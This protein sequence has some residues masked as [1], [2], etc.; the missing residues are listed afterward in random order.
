MRSG[1]RIDFFVLTS[2]TWKIQYQLCMSMTLY[3]LLTSC[4]DYWSLSFVVGYWWL[5][6]FLCNSI[7]ILS[8]FESFS[9]NARFRFGSLLCAAHCTQEASAAMLVTSVTTCGSF[10]AN[11]FSVIKVVRTGQ[12][13]SNGGNG[14]GWTGFCHVWWSYQKDVYRC[15]TSGILAMKIPISQ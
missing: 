3:R 11:S 12:R 10:Y 14:G 2:L 7:S 6:C 13:S 4:D 15:I 8:L 9:P 1:E 5:L